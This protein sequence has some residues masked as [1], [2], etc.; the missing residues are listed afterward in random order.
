MAGGR[1]EPRGRRPSRAP[2]W[3]AA[4]GH[5]TTRVCVGGG[6]K[7]PT[8]GGVIKIFWK[9]YQSGDFFS[10]GPDPT[11]K[12]HPEPFLAARLG[13]PPHTAHPTGY[14]PRSGLGIYPKGDTIFKRLPSPSLEGAAAECLLL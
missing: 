13:H 2:H 9:L 12:L 4:C 8:P 10:R 3:E 7:F 1:P 6:H 11:S 14:P 5:A